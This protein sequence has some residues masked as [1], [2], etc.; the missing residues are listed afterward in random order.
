M[1][2][3]RSKVLGRGKSFI[4]MIGLRPLPSA[5]LYRGSEAEI[6]ERAVADLELLEQAGADAVL[7]ENS[8]D[9]PYIKSTLAERDL[10][11]I[12]SVC[13]AIRARSNLPVGLQILEAHNRTALAIAARSSL[14][15]IRVEAFVFAHVGGAGLIEGCAGELLRD[16]R[17]L[18]AERI[19]VFADIQKKHCAHGLTSD[20]SIEDHARQSEFFLADGLIVTGNRTGS[21]PSQEDLITVREASTLPI[22][23]GSGLTA[24]NL[25][26][27]F[28]LANGFIVGT[29]LRKEARYLGEIDP[30]RLSAFADRFHGLKSR[31]EH[32]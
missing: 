19:Q 15:F 31:Q 14:D 28:G 29:D 1:D 26:S 13:H 23:V 32:G 21:A 3:G 6:L 10:Q 4:G 11:L 16:R 7:V 9:L 18:R 30:F 5:P 12:E 17:R 20:L 27:Y 8:G 24:E 25:E 2:E 22:L